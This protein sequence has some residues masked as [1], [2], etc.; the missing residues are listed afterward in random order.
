MNKTVTG[1]FNGLAGVVTNRCLGLIDYRAIRGP[2]GYTR[3]CLLSILNA[4]KL[5]PEY[6][7]DRDRSDL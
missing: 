5:S 4:S 3:N 1:D 7:S 6:F 2:V